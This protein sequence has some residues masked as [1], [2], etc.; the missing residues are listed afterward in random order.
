MSAWDI[1]SIMGF[2][3]VNPADGHFV[4]GA[5]QASRLVIALP[6]NNQFVIKANN[7]SVAN[8]Y[9]KSISLNGK[10]YE[11]PYITYKEIMAGGELTFE[12]TE[13]PM[14]PKF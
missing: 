1:F 12:M 4:F 9:V 13:K 3:P 2:Y 14:A 10:V 5:P 8:K 6:G 7:L 11:K